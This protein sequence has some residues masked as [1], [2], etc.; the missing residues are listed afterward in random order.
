MHVADLGADT[1]TL[2]CAKQAADRLLLE[3]PGLLRDEHAALHRRVKMMTEK[4]N[5]TLN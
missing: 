1:E 3:D 4:W 5:G 2:M